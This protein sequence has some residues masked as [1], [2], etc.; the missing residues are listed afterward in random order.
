[1]ARV[2]DIPFPLS[3]NPGLRTQESGG[4]IINGYLDALPASSKAKRIYRRAPGLATWGTTSRSGFRGMVEIGGILYAAFSGQLEKWS[5][6]VG[7]ASTNVGALNGTKK[8]FFARNNAATP[9]KVFVDP[10]GNIA[11]FTPTTVT[12]SYPD[13]DLPAVNSACGIDGYMVFTTGNGRAYATGLNV[14]SVDALSFGA[15]EAKADALTRAIPFAGQLL[16]MGPFSTE[17]WTNQG[18]TP[19]PFARSVVIPRGIAGP[20]CVTGHEDGF[21]KALLMVGD[22]NRVHVLQGYEFVAVS[23]PDLDALIEA[24]SDKTLIHM[25]SFMSRGHAFVQVTGPTF[26]WFFDLNTRQWFERQSYGLLISRI[27]GAI[28]VNVFGKWLTGDFSSGHVREITATAQDETG[29]PFRLRIESGAVIDFPAG[30][31]VGRADFDFITGV[32]IASGTDPIQTNPKVEVSWSD[33]GGQDWSA[34]LERELGRQSVT[35]G[36]VSLVGCTG[37]STWNGRR[38]RLDIS[39]PVVAGFMG[40]LQSESPRKAD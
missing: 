26:S 2:A 38:W 7:G 10:D 34:A 37:R 1:M 17:I 25:C 6:S 29:S 19:F 21:G 9:D 22:D 14:T 5:T 28:N 40:G 24:V 39:D 35:E 20:Y 27:I 12:N 33:D 23:P 16:L 15:A 13:A 4:R 11:T 31:R 3:S 18:T 30:E 8:G 32:G 36:L